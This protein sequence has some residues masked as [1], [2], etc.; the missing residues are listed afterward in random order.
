MLRVANFVYTL[1]K[2]F[3]R[4]GYNDKVN[5]FAVRAVSKLQRRS[6]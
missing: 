6:Y 5:H 2:G 3:L 4:L 1:V